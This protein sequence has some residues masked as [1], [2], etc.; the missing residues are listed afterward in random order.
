M[1]G[2]VHTVYVAESFV[3]IASSVATH[4]LI[5]FTEKLLKI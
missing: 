3:A 4:F 2:C 5:F 1:D